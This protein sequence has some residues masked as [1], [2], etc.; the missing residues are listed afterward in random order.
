MCLNLCRDYTVIIYLGFLIF[1]PSEPFFFFGGEKMIVDFI[2]LNHIV[3]WG[4][5]KRGILLTK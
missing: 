4:R 3:Q 1:D 2:Q 5:G